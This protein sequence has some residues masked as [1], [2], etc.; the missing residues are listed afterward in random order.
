MLKRTFVGAVILSLHF[1]NSCAAIKSN[2]ESV[3]IGEP[4]SGKIDSITYNIGGGMLPNQISIKFTTKKHSTGYRGYIPNS[5]NSTDCNG[6]RINIESSS[7]EN[8]SG[9][10][11]YAKF[12]NN[13]SKILDKCELKQIRIYIYQNQ[14]NEKT[15]EDETLKYLGKLNDRGEWIFELVQ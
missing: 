14:L 12:Y 5:I 11:V 15:S 13:R 4:T 3:V 9:T 6:K 1:L 2:E 8:F 7:F 10:F